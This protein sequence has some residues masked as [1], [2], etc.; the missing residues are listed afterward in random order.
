M[1]GHRG[2]LH[3]PAP[4]HFKRNI[5]DRINFQDVKCIDFFL[6]WFVLV[7]FVLEARGKKNIHGLSLFKSFSWT[8]RTGSPELQWQNPCEAMQAQSDKK[9]P[10]LLIP[11]LYRLTETQL[12]QKVML[13]YLGKDTQKFAFWNSAILSVFELLK[14]T[15]YIA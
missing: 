9:L 15:C 14:N 13:H 7:C 4:W 1:A 12:L 2:M 3:T 10:A 11:R 5:A 6:F 8:D